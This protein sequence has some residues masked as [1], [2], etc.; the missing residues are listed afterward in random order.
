MARKHIFN[1]KIKSNVEFTKMSCINKMHPPFFL[2]VEGPSG[3]QVSLKMSW[4]C[5]NIQYKP[6]QAHF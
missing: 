1:V 5:T 4:F 6:T 2:S 3:I